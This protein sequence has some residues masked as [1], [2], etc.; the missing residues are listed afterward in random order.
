MDRGK[1]RVDPSPLLVI[2]LQA[3]SSPVCSLSTS[4]VNC[5][6]ESRRSRFTSPRS[7]LLALIFVA[8]QRVWSLPI[9]TKNTYTFY[10]DSNSMSGHCISL[11]P[12]NN[13]LTIRQFVSTGP[14]TD[15]HTADPYIYRPHRLDSGPNLLAPLPTHYHN[16]RLSFNFPAD[17]PPPSRPPIPNTRLPCLVSQT[18]PRPQARTVVTSHPGSSPRLVSPLGIDAVLL[19]VWRVAFA[20]RRVT[21][22]ENLFGL[23]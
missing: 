20:A 8:V 3:D 21:F 6:A 15:V 5:L 22:H 2:E 10:L 12:A 23:G 4:G 19:A 17:L 9:A 1:V 18:R 13:T 11:D 7:R 14:Q 16:S